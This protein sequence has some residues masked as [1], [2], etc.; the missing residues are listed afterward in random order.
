MN[1]HQSS[2]KIGTDS[3][4]LGSWVDV[5]PGERILD[6][7][8]GCGVLA[9]MMAQ[10]NSEANIEAVEF[11]ELSAEEAAFNFHRSPWPNRLKVHC[12]SFQEFANRPQSTLFNHLI[13]NPPYFMAASKSGNARKDAA[14]HTD[15]LPFQELL[16]GAKKILHPQG[17]FHL[18]LPE[19]E[20]RHLLEL[21]VAH[22]FFLQRCCEVRPKTGKAI[23][24]LLLTLG[25]E[26]KPTET[27]RIVHRAANGDYSE[28]YHALTRDFYPSLL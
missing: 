3:V 11:D 23:R 28:A 19:T 15:H 2:F 27:E 26:N 25:F 13:S 16:E 12:Q 14:R 9:L 10:R 6:I 8:T 24:R 4:L 17:K 22:G 18:V 20:G 21:S 7:G 5:V 1:H